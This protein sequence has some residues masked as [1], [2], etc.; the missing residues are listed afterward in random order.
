MTEL[1]VVVE[2]EVLDAVEVFEIVDSQDAEVAQY[3]AGCLSCS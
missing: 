3:V 2:A 1:N